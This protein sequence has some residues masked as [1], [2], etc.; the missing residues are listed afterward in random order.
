MIAATNGE[1][2]VM[3]QERTFRADWLSRQRTDY[4]GCRTLTFRRGQ[5]TPVVTLA[6]ADR[7]HLTRQ[8]ETARAIDR[9]FRADIAIGCLI[10][11]KLRR[12][13]LARLS[14][15]TMSTAL[16]MRN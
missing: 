10:A 13:W 3:V 7:A 15:H 9:R 2:L 6:E 16:I 1:L 5:L 14:E 11:A 8:S 4:C 12:E